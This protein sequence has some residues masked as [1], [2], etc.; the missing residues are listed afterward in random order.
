MAT[1]LKA[2]N[3]SP[4]SWKVCRKALPSDQEIRITPTITTE[5]EVL[6][7]T[8]QGTEVTYT[9]PAAASVASICT[10]LTALF[11]A[12]V[13]VEA[14]DDTS[15]VTLTPK[16]VAS[17]TLTVDTNGA[18]TYTVTIDGEDYAFT[19]TAETKT[20]IRDGLQALILVDYDAAECVDNGT[21]ALDFD[22][23]SH[24]GADV[25]ETATGGT[26]SISA[27]VSAYRLLSIGGASTG[28]TVKDVTA[29]PG[30]ATD[31][32]AI[33]AE[34]SDFYG[35]GLDSQ[36]E[37]EI[38]ALAAQVETQRMLFVTG[39][40]DTEN[41]DSG[42]TTDVCSDLAAAGY[43]RT[44]ALQ[45]SYNS[46]YAG[47]RWMGKMLPKDPGSATWAYKTLAGLTVSVLTAAQ[48]SALDGKYCNRYQ[49]VGGV[50]VTQKGYAAS[51]EFIDI[52][53]GA[54]W[55]QV[56]LQERIYGLLVNLDKIPYA[57]AGGL[58]Y[59]EIY[60][61][62]QEAAKRSVIAPDTEDT[63]WVITIPEVADISAANKA[64]RNFPDV[65]FSAYLAGAVH[66]VTITGTLS[67]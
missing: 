15:Y 48:E 19:A 39:Q 31:W 64:L 61:Q 10:A 36:S 42:T 33:L 16:N 8:V 4:S 12:I 27:E 51:G 14:S 55:F 57:Q 26:M 58:L 30:I 34:D 18:G 49:S 66:K 47:C 60:A 24:A 41:T 43:Y 2:Q 6:R 44:I 21:D 17:C 63:P 23:S 29:D 32:A 20:Q 37:A 22:F 38:N 5:G 40:I 67:R 62:M 3:P 45:A 28:L 25:R 35:V 56:R 53:R 13:G 9:I 50:S 65:E 54:D 46:Q 59:A 11:A 1:A 52:T 7:L